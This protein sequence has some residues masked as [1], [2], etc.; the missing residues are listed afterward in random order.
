MRKTVLISKLNIIWHFPPRIKYVFFIV[1][2]NLCIIFI[3]FYYAI[4]HTN[5]LKWELSFCNWRMMKEFITTSK[6]SGHQPLVQLL[7]SPYHCACHPGWRVASCPLI[8]LPGPQCSEAQSEYASVW[9]LTLLT[10]S[11]T[12][13]QWEAAQHSPER[14]TKLTGMCQNLAKTFFQSLQIMFFGNKSRTVSFWNN[15]CPSSFHCRLSELPWPMKENGQT[16][17][18]RQAHLSCC[19]CLVLMTV[20]CLRSKVTRGSWVSRTWGGHSCYLMILVS[21]RRHSLK[22]NLCFFKF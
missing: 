1:L 5:L 17:M 7:P 9:E 18:F 8:L 13:E 11:R 22:G 3:L 4:T 20:S 12:V 21:I 6:V 16:D 19:C 15:E 10:R 14:Q 2:C